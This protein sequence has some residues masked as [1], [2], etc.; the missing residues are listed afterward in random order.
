MKDPK[1]INSF[2]TTK[3]AKQ[4]DLEHIMGVRFPYC[5]QDL[6][7]VVVFEVSESKINSQIS[8]Y[9]FS[10][11]NNCC[12]FQNNS[13]LQKLICLSQNVLIFYR[14]NFCCFNVKHQLSIGNTQ[15]FIAK[16]VFSVR[17]SM[18]LFKT[19]GFQ[20]KQLIKTH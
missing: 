2:K 9:L 8:F 13:F 10:I 15:L 5:V 17:H 1:I 18:L 14:K 16:H 12:L 3:Q 20:I 7:F 4:V 11:K 6:L 19:C